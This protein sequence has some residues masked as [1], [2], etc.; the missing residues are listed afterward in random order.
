MKIRKWS[1]A[2]VALI[3]VTYSS[4]SVDTGSASAQII[5]NF[6]GPF[7][8]SQCA[9]EARRVANQRVGNRSGHSS[10]LG[11]IAGGAIGGFVHGTSANRWQAVYNTAYRACI[12]R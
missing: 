8:T 11:S 9:R 4:E 2:L 1:V 5:Q 6:A 10:G 12:N 3:G 7:R